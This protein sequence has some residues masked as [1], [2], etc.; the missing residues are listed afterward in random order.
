MFQ[1]CAEGS[2]VPKIF[3]ILGVRDGFKFV[4][5]ISSLYTYCWLTFQV[6]S[7]YS[8]HILYF[9]SAL[10]TLSSI[11]SFTAEGRGAET[12]YRDRVTGKIVDKQA[13]AESRQRAG[14]KNPEKT[15]EE[16]EQEQVLDGSRAKQN[17]LLPFSLYQTKYSPSNSC[18]CACQMLRV[19]QEASYIISGSML[20][21][22]VGVGRVVTLY[23]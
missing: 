22:L 3:T 9:K 20:Y 16:L 10:L 15:K 5:Y 2:R 8:C 17:T 11:C 14:K 13:F 7:F 18:A 21:Y 1:G 6:I 12:V 4:R 23:R 19:Q